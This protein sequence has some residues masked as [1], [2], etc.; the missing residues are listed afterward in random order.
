MSL[1]DQYDAAVAALEA[2]EAATDTATASGT[3]SGAKRD[4]IDEVGTAARGALAVMRQSPGTQL[5]GLG[6]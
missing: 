5:R 4:A 6:I 3:Y 1:A 2:L